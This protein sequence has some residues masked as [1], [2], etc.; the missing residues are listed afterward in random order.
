MIVRGGFMSEPNVLACRR[1]YA[2]VNLCQDQLICANLGITWAN[3]WLSVT[4][5]APSS[6]PLAPSHLPPGVIAGAGQHGL[7]TNVLGTASDYLL[8]IGRGALQPLLT[9][10]PCGLGKESLVLESTTWRYRSMA[11]THLGVHRRSEE[12]GLSQSSNIRSGQRILTV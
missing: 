10:R 9:V 7:S 6:S 4:D 2:E 12:L 1:H 3:S 5:C 11:E 8:L